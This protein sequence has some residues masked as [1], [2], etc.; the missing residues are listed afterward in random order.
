V[1]GVD[2][3]V[4]KLVDKADPG[5]ERTKFTKIHPKGGEGVREF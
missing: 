4:A 5:P 3:V 1:H 2:G